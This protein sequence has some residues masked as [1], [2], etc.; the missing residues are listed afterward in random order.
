[1]RTLTLTVTPPLAGRM[2]QHVLRHELLLSSALIARLKRRPEGICV[3]GK[4]VFT[5]YQLQEGDVL[6]VEIGDPPTARRA[7][8]V[9]MP[10]DIL[11]EDDDILILNKP[12]GITVHADSRRPG[13]TTLDHALSAYLPSDAFAHP[14]S[15]LDRGTT[16]VMTYAKS[17]YM[18]DRLRRMLHTPEFMREYRAICIG[19][20]DPP[21][22]KIE[23]PIG[24]AEDSTYQRAVTPGGAPSLTEYETLQTFDGRSLMQLVPRTGRTH[25]LR[26]HMAAIGCPLAGDWLYGV[27]DDAL[28]ARPALHSASLFLIHPLTGARIEAVAPL[29]DDMRRLMER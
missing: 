3:N 16:G 8:P 1:M 2:V 29:P 4:K 23:L 26:V 21:A 19:M 28:I 5:I 9:P 14:V 13:E 12:A 17:G 24:F 15:R 7:A 20:P 6:R 10:L 18:H 25:Q 27:R 22:G 11:F